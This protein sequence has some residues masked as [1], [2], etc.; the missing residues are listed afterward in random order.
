MKNKSIII[1]FIIFLSIIIGLISLKILSSTIV[2]QL[3]SVDGPTVPN[4]IGIEQNESINILMDNNI[5]AITE[6]ED[7][8]NY[9]EGTVIR[10]S[11]TPGL[12]IDKNTIITVYISKKK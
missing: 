4:I 8:N 5:L 11:V 1:I 10:L 12:Q 2:K 3:N 7:N 9:P 6:I